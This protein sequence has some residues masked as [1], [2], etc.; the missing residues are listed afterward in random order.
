[1]LETPPVVDGLVTG[2]MALVPELGGWLDWPHD[3]AIVTDIVSSTAAAAAASNG[4][5]LKSSSLPKKLSIVSLTLFIGYPNSLLSPICA[6][7]SAVC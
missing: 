3:R 2:S 4:A 5:S 1:M 6:G 7:S